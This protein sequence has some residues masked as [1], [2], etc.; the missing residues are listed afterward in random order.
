[1]G[2]AALSIT[3]GRSQFIDY[4]VAIYEEPTAI[5]IPPATEASKLTACVKPFQWQVRSFRIVVR[6]A[7]V[8]FTE[9]G[10][11]Q[12]WLALLSMVLVLPPVLRF[13]LRPPGWTQRQ[14]A[15][16]LDAFRSFQFVAGVLL[17]QCEPM[18]LSN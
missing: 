16:Q 14:P 11:Q 6:M 5:L 10:S 17:S 12:V 18:P 8:G 1:M 15:G 2:A 4:T 9:T 13:L 3:Y 7:I